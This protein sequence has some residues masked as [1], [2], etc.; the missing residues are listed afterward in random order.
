MNQYRITYY[1]TS[2][3]EEPSRYFIEKQDKA[4]RAKVARYIKLLE[5]Y[6]PNL[7]M[8]HVRYLKSGLYE[9]RIRGQNELRIFYIALTSKR[10]VM[11]LHA[12]RKRTQKTPENELKIARSRRSELT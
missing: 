9:L 1:R 12:F 8:P 4:T 10:T 7:G 6:G 3:G 5:A 11:F 2:R